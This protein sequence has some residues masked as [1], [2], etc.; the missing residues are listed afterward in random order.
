LIGSNADVASD[1]LDNAAAIGYNAEVGASDSLIL[2]GTGDDAV[3]VGIGTTTPDRT[4][5]IEMSSTGDVST[6][7]VEIG[8]GVTDPD[9]TFIKLRSPDGSEWYVFPNNAGTLVCTTTEP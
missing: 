6:V 8:Q 2:G 1:G 3:S 9:V 5:E 4:F 7:D